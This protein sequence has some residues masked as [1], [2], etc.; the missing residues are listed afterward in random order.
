MLFLNDTVTIYPFSPPYV[1]QEG[2]VFVWLWVAAV[3]ER[4]EKKEKC[5]C[6]MS[7]CNIGSGATWPT[8]LIGWNQS[9][10]LLLFYCRRGPDMLIVVLNKFRQ[11]AP[12]PGGNVGSY[13]KS[14]ELII[15][16]VFCSCY[17]GDKLATI[18]CQLRPQR[19]GVISDLA[20]GQRAPC[21][22]RLL[23]L[24]LSALYLFEPGTSSLDTI[25]VTHSGF[26][27]WLGRRI[28]GMFLCFNHL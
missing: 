2:A 15:K 26:C 22:R 25:V 17:A 7:F 11:R 18:H 3:A 12:P 8:S 14:A 6:Q 24:R 16:A 4:G 5:D 10:L 23:R 13:C 9:K 1:F 27:H 28:A 19:S 21:G 20:S